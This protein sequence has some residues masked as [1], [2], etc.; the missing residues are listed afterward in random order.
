VDIHLVCDLVFMVGGFVL[1]LSLLV[2]VKRKIEMPAA[3]TLPTAIVLTAFAVCFV[4]LEL[5]L[6]VVS[7]AL[8]AGCWYI[9]YFRNWLA[10]D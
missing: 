7:T 2:S 4:L 5:Y 6:A 1:L 9:L 10:G 3:T 8:T